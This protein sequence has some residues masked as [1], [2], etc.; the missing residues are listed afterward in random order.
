MVHSPGDTPPADLQTRRS[1]YQ[2]HRSDPCIPYEESIGALRDLLDEGKIRMVGISNA[3]P[4]QIQLANRILGGRL[5][6]VQNGY[7]PAFGSSEPKLRLCDEL[8]VAFLPRSPFG[9][10]RKA[11]QLGHRFTP[12]QQVTAAHGVSPHRLWLAWT[13][14]KAPVVIP[15]PW[16]SRPE[17]IRDSAAATGLVLSDDEIAQ[18]ERSL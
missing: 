4:D 13:P 16:A 8:G 15:I 18:L 14:A 17:T 7:S 1:L 5:A 9:G 6:S 2:H 3:N 11:G 10:I 12:F